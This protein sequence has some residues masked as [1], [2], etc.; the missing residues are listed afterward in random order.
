MGRMDA[1]GWPF[2]GE[3]NQMVR[4]MDLLIKDVKDRMQGIWTEG[5][6]KHHGK[7]NKADAKPKVWKIKRSGMYFPAEVGKTL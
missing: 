1:H 4:Q 6:Y 5:K 2:E 7:E 3:K